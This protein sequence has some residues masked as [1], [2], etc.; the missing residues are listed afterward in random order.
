[1]AKHNWTY[2]SFRDGKFMVLCRD[3]ARVDRVVEDEASAMLRIQFIRK[4]GPGESKVAKMFRP[5]PRR[6]KKIRV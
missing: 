1:M 2:K 5:I 3:C 6:K 4:F